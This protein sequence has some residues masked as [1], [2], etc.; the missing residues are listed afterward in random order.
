MPQAAFAPYLAAFSSQ[1]L[2]LGIV[3]GACVLLGSVV[4]LRLLAV[5]T[6]WM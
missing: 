1:S 6:R 2:Y 4:L 5:K 3:V